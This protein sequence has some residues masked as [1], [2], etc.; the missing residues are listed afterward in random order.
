MPIQSII[1]GQELTIYTKYQ[2]HHPE[3][4]KIDI[5]AVRQCVDEFI[6]MPIFIPDASDYSSMI[7]KAVEQR[8]KRRLPL[9]R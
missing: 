9:E 5:T 1:G 8:I 6:K 7:N 4:E 3:M 2:E